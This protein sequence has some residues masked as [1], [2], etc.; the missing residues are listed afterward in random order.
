VIELVAASPAHVGRIATRMR[1][2][3]VAEVEAFGRTPKEALRLG[4]RGSSLAATVKVDGRPEAMLGVAPVSVIEGVGRPWMLGTDAVPRCARALL[5]DGHAVIGEM[6]RRFRRLENWVSADNAPAIRL[7]RRWGFEVGA[8][9]MT[10]SGVDFV[11]F[12]REASDV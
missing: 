3:D 1:A 6:R 9:A 7:L 11:L 12:W 2:A 5:A 10:V 4:L 8:E